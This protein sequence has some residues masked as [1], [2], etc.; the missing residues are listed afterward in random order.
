MSNIIFHPEVDYIWD[1]DEWL[2][3]WE[4]WKLYRKQLGIKSWNYVPIGEKRTLTEIKG[5]AKNDPKNAIALVIHAMSKSWRGIHLPDNWYNKPR[6]GR[7]NFPNEWNIEFS[8]KLS[9]PEMTDYYHHLRENCKLKPVHHKGN[10]VKWAPIN[11]I[12]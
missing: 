10:L 6:N 5:F 11:Q 4:E 8:K 2:D 7:L 3:V 9:G 1:D 12:T